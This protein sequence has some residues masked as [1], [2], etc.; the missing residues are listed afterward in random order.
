MKKPVKPV[1]KLLDNTRL[2]LKKAGATEGT[3][4]KPEQPKV[5]LKVTVPPTAVARPAPTTASAK[6]VLPVAKP[7]PIQ[8]AQISKIKRETDVFSPITPDQGGVRSDSE[9]SNSGP[10]PAMADLVANLKNDK[11]PLSKDKLSV[12]R[13]LMKQSGKDKDSFGGD[14]VKRLILRRAASA[15]SSFLV[16]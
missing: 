11:V 14:D 7:V 12:L 6:L 15:S 2:S 5:I 9:E 4:P 13:H 8:T 3:E 10:D 1:R 16:A